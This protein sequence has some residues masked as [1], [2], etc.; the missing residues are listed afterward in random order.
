MIY[1]WE[2]ESIIS[3]FLKV[4]TISLTTTVQK[5]FLPYFLPLGSESQVSLS[6]LPTLVQIGRSEKSTSEERGQPWLF[7]RSRR[8]LK[9]GCLIISQS[10][11]HFL[12][13]IYSLSAFQNL[14]L[15]PTNP[16]NM[17]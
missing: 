1:D 10:H 3:L 8:L 6:S 13:A 7:I 11:L 9:L 12:T 5:T 2:S 14:V 17:S 16:G 15:D 4:N